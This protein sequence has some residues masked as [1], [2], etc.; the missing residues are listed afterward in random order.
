V[1]PVSR[2]SISA[3]SK[4]DA[5]NISGKEKK[6][7]RGP[8]YDQTTANRRKRREKPKRQIPAICLDNARRKTSR[9]RVRVRVDTESL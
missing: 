5:E 7:R 6:R 3:T 1:V 8:L 4:Q 9:M 2:E